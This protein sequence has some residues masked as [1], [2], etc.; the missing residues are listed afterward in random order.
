MRQIYIRNF[1]GRRQMIVHKRRAKQPAVFVVT[2]FL[3]K[4]GA[5]PLHHRSLV[6]CVDDL[7]IDHVAA[8]MNRAVLDDLDESRFDV[9]VHHGDDRRI[10][11]A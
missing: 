1:F 11:I 2:Q 5:D 8:V 4:R 3:V 6:L 7:R 10:R 9:H